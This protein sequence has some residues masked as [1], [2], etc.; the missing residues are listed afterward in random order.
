MGA[1]GPLGV[2]KSV[3]KKE[4]KRGVDERGGGIVV[5]FCSEVCGGGF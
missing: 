4:R 2:S 1:A 5:G 3:I